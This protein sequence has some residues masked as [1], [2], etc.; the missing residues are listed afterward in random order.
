MTDTKLTDPLAA[1]P[2]PERPNYTLGVMLDEKDFVAEQTYHRA[3]LARAM[4]FA[5]GTGTLVGLAGKH[6][7]A[8]D[9]PN[10]EITVAPGIAVDDIG[11][12][13]EVPKKMCI[14]LSRWWD[15]QTTDR[16]VASFAANAITADLFVRFVA[17]GRGRTPAFA[18]GPFDA[19]DATVHGRIVDGA[20]VKLVVQDAGVAAPKDPWA[21]VAATPVAGRIGKLRQLITNATLEVAPDPVVP[22]TLDPSLHWVFL[23]RVTFPAT[24][25]PGQRPARNGAPTV[26]NDLRPIVVSNAALLRLVAP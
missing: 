14:S 7:P 23:A 20:E 10:E 26:N 25:A 21:E 9:T 24:R 17:C 13:I 11:R 2:Q 15:A 8:T 5:T 18:S 6:A 22:R 3:R 4:Q 12:L 19:L 1:N 16:L